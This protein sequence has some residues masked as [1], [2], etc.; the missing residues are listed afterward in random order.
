MPRPRITIRRMMAAVALVAVVTWGWRLMKLRE[1][2][3]SRA[4]RNAILVLRCT[5]AREAHDQ[6]IG[7]LSAKVLFLQSK[8]KA[9]SSK[10]GTASG[11]SR[12]DEAITEA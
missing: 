4:R 1:D 2:Y 12:D 11:M 7:S 6:P 5:E 9:P 3:R 8:A 10:T